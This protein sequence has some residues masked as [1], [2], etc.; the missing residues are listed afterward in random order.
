MTN[1][2][3][4]KSIISRPQDLVTSREA[5]QAG[6]LEQARAKVVK[7]GPLVGR[8]QELR[9]ELQRAPNLTGLAEDRKLRKQLMAAAGFSAKSSKYF[10][11]SEL[12][13][14]LQ[15]I[16]AQIYAGCASSQTGGD[17]AAIWDAFCQEVVARYLL[18]E[19]DA[20]GGQMRNWIGAR[21]QTRL[22]DALIGALGN[23]QV[24][25]QRN[26]DATKI[27]RLSWPGRAIYFDVKPR[28]LDKNIDVIMLSVPAAAPLER[29]LLEDATNYL[30]CGELKGG[31][32]PAGADEHWK[33]AKSALDR[34]RS[35]RA[36]SAQPLHLFFVGAAI[37]PTVAEEIFRELQDGRLSDA[38][39]LTVQPQVE[40]LARWLVAL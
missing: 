38:A 34:I 5:T 40:A 12:A 28:L 23:S 17:Q 20:L 31:I 6:F 10:T 33:T 32:D 18:S 24:E 22:T 25:V 26:Q 29:D 21:A 8:A 30:A 37:A 13:E 3:E 2:L 19:G 27:Q 14:L 4:W 35:N 15:Q 16:L 7:A 1:G 11:K 36:F 9:A 39:N